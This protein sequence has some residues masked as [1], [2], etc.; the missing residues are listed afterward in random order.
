MEKKK[1]LTSVSATSTAKNL[2]KQISALVDKPV[3]VIVEE[4]ASRELARLQK[5][6]THAR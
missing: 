3:Y 6:K 2:L 5:G 4:L 1:P